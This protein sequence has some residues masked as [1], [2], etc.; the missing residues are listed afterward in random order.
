M[1]QKNYWLIALVF[2]VGVTLSIFSC[3]HSPLGMDEDVTP[4]DTTGNNNN[5]DTSTAGTPCD[6]NVVYFEWD[7]LPI[8][9]SNCALSGCHDEASHEDGVVLTTYEKVMSTADVD[10]FRPG[11]SKLYK[12]ITDNDPEDRMPPAPNQALSSA[13]AG[14]INQWIQQGA[15]N[16]SCD[17]N[18]GVCNTDN[19]SYVQDI[20]PV[21]Q[22]NCLG[23][24]SG[25][26]PSGGVLLDSHANVA[27]AAGNGRLYGAISWQNGYVPM[28]FGAS[29]PLAQCTVDK[30]KSWVDAGAPNN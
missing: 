7:I 23:C 5:P 29:N 14:L 30:I 19:V 1:E 28:P 8:L 13:Q 2:G 15:K 26:A 25:S 24:H 20:R 21:I 6:P 27:A 3:K 22:N 18:A 11:N 9:R 4:I 16:E 12:M 17:Q 10:P